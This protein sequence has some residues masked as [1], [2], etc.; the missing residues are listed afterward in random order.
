MADAWDLETR[1]GSVTVTLPPSFNADI[2]AETRD[3]SVRST[4]PALK[5]DGDDEERRERRREVR[6]RMGEGG[7][8]L[9]IR[10]GDGSIRFES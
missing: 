6:T 4:H 7:R 9:K 1:D 10:T 5:T 3:G 8:V 2:D